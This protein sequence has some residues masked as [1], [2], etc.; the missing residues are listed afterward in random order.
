MP[1]LNNSHFSLTHSSTISGMWSHI[2]AF[3]DTLAR[4]LKRASASITR[5]TPERL[6]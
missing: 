1:W 4:T 3:S 2:A 5:Q 6:P